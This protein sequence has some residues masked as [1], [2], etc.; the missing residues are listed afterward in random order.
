M[1]SALYSAREFLVA[2][3]Y[4]IDLSVDNIL[5]LRYF[6]EQIHFLNIT[7]NEEVRIAGF[8]IL[9]SGK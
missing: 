2:P 9:S 3:Q 8:C 1:V 5:S 7:Y 6:S 4:V